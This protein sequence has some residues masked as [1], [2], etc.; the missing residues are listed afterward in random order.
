MAVFAALLAGLIV[1]SIS[2]RPAAALAAGLVLLAAFLAAQRLTAL[3]PLLSR[4]LA[5]RSS[6]VSRLRTAAGARLWY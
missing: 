6:A 4:V 1:A 2:G 3:T 5:W